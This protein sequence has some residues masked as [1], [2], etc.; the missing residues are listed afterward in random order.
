MSTGETL[1]R[2]VHNEA[3]YYKYNMNLLSH[4]LFYLWWTSP[5]TLE[6]AKYS[7]VWGP[8]V[9]KCSSVTPVTRG[10]LSS[11]PSD[12][13]PGWFGDTCD[14]S[15]CL[16]VLLEMTHVWTPM[17]RNQALFI[18][19]LTVVSNLQY[20]ATNTHK[21]FAVCGVIFTEQQSS[22]NLCVKYTV[23]SGC[24]TIKATVGGSTG[25]TFNV[26]Q[27]QEMMGLH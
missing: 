25:W 21:T 17:A 9:I 2:I 4:S 15:K 23:S 12:F 22:T 24:F 8:N 20:L 16:S 26:K 13:R 11:T 18:W 19:Q 3:I 10:F 6:F 5:L 1:W 14:N 27:Q 7:K